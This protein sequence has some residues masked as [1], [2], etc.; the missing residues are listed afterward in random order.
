MKTFYE[1]YE[2]LQEERYF[3]RLALDPQ[4]QFG[5]ERQPLLGARILPE[6]IVEENAYEETQVRYR[7]RPALDNNRYSP[8]Q[9]QKNGHL[10]GSFRV[11]LGH[12]D[13]QK[14]LTGK[15]YDDLRKLL[16][17]GGDMEAMSRVIGWTDLEL[18][19]PHVIKNEIQR[20][21][22][23]LTAVTT[24]QTINGQM[25]PINYYRPADHV[26][27]IPGGTQAAPQGWNLNTYDPFD[28][29]E[30][31]LEKLNGLGYDV[32]SMYATPY[33][34]RTLRLNAEVI[35]RTSFVVVNS[36]SE[37]VSSTNR[38]SNQILD[39]V[40]TDEGY[41]VLTRYNGGYESEVGFNRYMDVEAGYDYLLMVGSTQRNYEIASDYVGATNT[42]ISGFTDGS[43]VL[44][45][46][47]GYYGVGRNPGKD[48]SG[49]TIHTWMNEKKPVGMGGESYQTGLPVITDPQAYYVIRVQRPTA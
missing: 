36:N 34:A 41:P 22:A 12:T 33:L 4:A 19:Q 9:K 13:T 44:N 21:Q 32:T 39:D 26:V 1:L 14:D 40:F 25:E 20:W 15:D 24:R 2:E 35:K 46:T 45:D 23:L 10:I 7:T 30:A 11:D 47:L 27:T 48:A 49:R 42:D 43:I 18:L 29:I 3:Q 16:M 17:R 31:G 38:V 6:R 37:I 28:D 8:T 5:S